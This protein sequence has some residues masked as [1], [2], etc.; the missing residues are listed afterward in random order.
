[1][2]IQR[3]RTVVD[4]SFPR[5]LCERRELQQ[6]LSAVALNVYR[7]GGRFRYPFLPAKSGIFAAK[8][9][10]PMLGTPDKSTT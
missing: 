7:R 10:T 4:P 5:D 6:S 9:P 2:E 3:L 1:L 8:V